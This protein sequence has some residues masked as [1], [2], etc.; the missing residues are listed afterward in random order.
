M[1]PMKLRAIAAAGLILALGAALRSQTPT[2]DVLI[3]NG[4][5]LDGTGTPAAAVDLAV[6]GGRIVS[7]GRIGQA[8]ARRTIDARGLTV[9]PGFIDVH[10]HSSQ[11]LEGSLKEGR[12]LIAQGITTVMI[13]PDG[14]GTVDL[15]SQ[16]AGFEQRGIGVNVAMYVPHGSIRREVLGMEDRAPTTAE[17]ERAL[18]K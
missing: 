11:G 18:K 16:R 15:R 2:Y 10:S 12:Q 8:T 7:V 13:N 9:T 6:V 1:S 14:G 17:L 5:V 4:R 3:R